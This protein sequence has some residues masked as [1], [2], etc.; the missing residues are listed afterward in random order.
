M[1]E[2][3][4]F[5]TPP[6]DELDL[7]RFAPCVGSQYQAGAFDGLKLLVLGESHY[8]WPGMPADERTLTRY[9]VQAKM[10]GEPGSFVRGVTATLLGAPHKS[11]LERAS[12]W[13]NLTFYNY[14]Q[15][16]AGDHA[17][18]RPTREHWEHAQ[19]SFRQ[20]LDVLS[21]SVVL[22]CGKTLWQHVRKIDG[23]SDEPLVNPN[24]DLERS[25]VARAEG[26][27]TVLGMM[28]HP[29]SIGFKASEWAPRVQR[30]FARAQGLRIPAS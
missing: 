25:R 29:S 9:V 24:D 12:L 5:S 4:D 23:L 11:E 30:Y 27:A 6:V 18:Q 13:R 21:P 22:V 2:A 7:C 3:F 8:R 16:F 19:A 14:S 20:V 26:Q 28:A 10:T 1:N 17:R 15:E